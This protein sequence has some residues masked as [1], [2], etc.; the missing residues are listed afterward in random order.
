MRRPALAVF[1]V[2]AAVSI[3]RASLSP[4]AYLSSTRILI[5]KSQVQNIGVT[6]PF[7]SS[8]DPDFHRTQVQIILSVATAERAARALVADDSYRDRLKAAIGGGEPP[9]AS[10]GALEERLARMIR[11][12]LSATP[13]KESKIVTISFLSNDP[14]L[15]ARVAGAVV[16]AYVDQFFE[17]KMSSSRYAIEWMTGKAREEGA[18]L[19]AAE[20]NLQSFI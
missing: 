13:E 16:K 10:D 2:A 6:T 8:W 4:P 18:R 12:S 9:G 3:V 15:S 1:V 19:D 20:R 17:M 7:Y 5:E 14:S 11:Q